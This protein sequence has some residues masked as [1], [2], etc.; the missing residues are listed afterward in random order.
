MSVQS[1]KFA[2][3]V[4]ILEDGDQRSIEVIGAQNALNAVNTIFQ[5]GLIDTFYTGDTDL[6]Y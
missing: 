3:N 1:N 6:S 4:P 5:E 2:R